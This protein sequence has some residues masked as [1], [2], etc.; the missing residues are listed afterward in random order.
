MNYEL[1]LLS[2]E[3]WT[4]R[5]SLELNPSTLTLSFTLKLELETW[6]WVL[7]IELWTLELFEPSVS[8]LGLRFQ[9]WPLLWSLSLELELWTLSFEPWTWVLISAVSHTFFIFLQRTIIFLQRTIPKNFIPAAD[10]SIPNENHINLNIYLLH[11]TLTLTLTNI[12]LHK[13]RYRHA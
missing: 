12:F 1:N 3:C 4:L 9:F 11:L 13:C 6:A 5:F 10:H 7:S 2:F 8:T